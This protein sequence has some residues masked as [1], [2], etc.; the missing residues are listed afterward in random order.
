[1]PELPE[2]EVICNDLKRKILNKKIIKT[3]IRTNKL[4]FKVSSK[5]YKLNNV[6]ILKIRR[7]AK[8]ILLKLSEGYI[9]IHLGISGTLNIMSQKKHIKFNK[10]DHIDLYINKKYILRY[11][12]PRK[13]GFWLFFFKIS[14]IKFLKKLGPEPLSD[15]L[16]YINLYKSIRN[17]KICI[18]NYLMNQKYISGIGNIYANEILFSSKILPYRAS[19]SLNIEETKKLVKYIKKILLKSIDKGGTSIRNFKNIFQI[20]GKYQKHLNVYG[21]TGKPCI[22]CKKSI[23]NII[24]SNRKSFF[25]A[26]CQL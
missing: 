15:N 24:Q 19:K 20:K 7:Y 9:L 5:F 12:D 17:K 3:C 23:L 18:K 1:M 22:N 6:L 13:F 21:K 2:V 8:Y 25:C 10:H 4:R 26:K 16:N 14:S 11:N